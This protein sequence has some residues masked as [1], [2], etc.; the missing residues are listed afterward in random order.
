MS[1]TYRQDKEF[2]EELIPETLLEKAI[3]WIKSNMEPQDVFEEEQLMDWAE[4]EQLI[5]QI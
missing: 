5:N 2:L 1:T 3:E 4:R